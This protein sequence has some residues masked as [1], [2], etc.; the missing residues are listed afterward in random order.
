MACASTF[1]HHLRLVTIC[2]QII[3]VDQTLTSQDMHRTSNP[4]QDH[5]L[6]DR[7]ASTTPLREKK[8]MQLSKILIVGGTLSTV[9]TALQRPYSVEVDTHHPVDESSVR[10]LRSVVGQDLTATIPG[11][12]DIKTVYELVRNAVE[13][14]RDKEC[15][16]SRKLVRTHEEEKQ[17]TKLIDGVEQQVSKKWTYSELSPYQYRTYR[18]V[19]DESIAIGAGLRKL[20]LN[21]S[22]H[23]GI[24]ADTSYYSPW[25]C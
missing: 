21:P 24:Y 2:T 7:T 11:H 20:G 6:R 8:S 9:A 3:P 1:H 18:D 4:A 5:V 12:P 16:G 19:G 15:L 14:W 25:R 10:R 23:V 17:V 22:D 13:Q